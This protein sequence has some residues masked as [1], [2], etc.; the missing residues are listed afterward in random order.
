MFA[1]GKKKI[2]F[3][4]AKLC[5]IDSCVR[6]CPL[7]SRCQDEYVRILFRETPVRKNG[8]RTRTSHR[9]LP[10]CEGGQK[11]RLSNSVLDGLVGSLRKIYQGHQGAVEL[12]LSSQNS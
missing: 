10:P 4:T 6:L 5:F 9:S 11:G 2:S 3:S 12:K 7:R 1:E 8:E